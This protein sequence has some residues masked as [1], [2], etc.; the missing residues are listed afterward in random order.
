ME[1]GKAFNTCNNILKNENMYRG[2]DNKSNINCN[3]KVKNNNM[4]TLLTIFLLYYFYFCE[5]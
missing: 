3:Y 4:T 5:K 2:K 1:T